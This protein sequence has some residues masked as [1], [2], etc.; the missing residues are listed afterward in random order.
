MRVGF[1]LV[2]VL[3]VGCYEKERAEYATYAEAERQGAVRRGWIP[4]YVPRSATDIAEAH[5][6]DANTQRLRFRLPPSDLPALLA[7]LEPLPPGAPLPRALSAPA[8]GGDWPLA[9]TGHARTRDAGISVYLARDASAAARCV[10]V[11]HARATVYAWSCAG[12]AG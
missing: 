12:R 11:A 5:D 7:Q 8:L 3:V 10:A 6:L 4:A 2:V 1:V 9:L